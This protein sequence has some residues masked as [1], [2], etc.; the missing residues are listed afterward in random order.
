MFDSENKLKLIGFGSAI[1]GKITNH[2]FELDIFKIGTL[3]YKM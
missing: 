3:L 2:E 1:Q